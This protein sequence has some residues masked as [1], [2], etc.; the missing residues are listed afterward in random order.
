LCFNLKGLAVPLLKPSN[1]P[2]NGQNDN[3][4]GD[5]DDDGGGGDDDGHD[6]GDVTQ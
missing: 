3:S 6:D 1:R 2:T 4:D 5:G